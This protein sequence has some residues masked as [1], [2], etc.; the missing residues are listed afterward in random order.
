M[1]FRDTFA[2]LRARH[3]FRVTSNRL[4]FFD[5]WKSRGYDQADAPGQTSVKIQIL[6]IVY[7]MISLDI[8][9]CIRWKV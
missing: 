1:S 7:T 4:R 9:C 5:F 8:C 3:E 6:S 2:S